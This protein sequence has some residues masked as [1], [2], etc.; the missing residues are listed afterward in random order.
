M[1]HNIQRRFVLAIGASL[2][3]ASASRFA[4]A[5]AAKSIKLIVPFPA[6]GTADVLPRILVEKVRGAYPAGIVVENKSGAGGNIGAEFVAR[7]DA[8]GTT[9]LVS[10]PGPIAINHH[11][12]KSLSFDP[13]K[14]VPVTV[15]ATV[16]N[17]LDVSN[18]L[19]VKSVAEFIAYLKA[20]PGKVSYASQGNGS[21][22]HLT[23][24]LFMELTG[25]KMVHV[26]Y[27]GTAPALV[28]IVA[29]NV[30]VFF[31]NISSS[32][33]FHI[34]N[35]LRVLAVADDERSPAL[36]SVPTFAQAGL[37]NMEAVTFF[38]MV[39]PPGTPKEVVAYAHKQ[40]AA[41]LAA[42]DVKQKFLEQGAVPGGWTPEKT[43]QFIRKESDRW[44]KVIK[45]ANV[46]VE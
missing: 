24:S 26:P 5:Q 15:I 33:Q 28:D 40:F 36:P 9:F 32:A 18:K 8:D 35:K 34:G 43:A 25:T 13:N 4:I 1:T 23:A 20:N 22:S 44:A 21:T 37:P 12:Y 42:P 6:G 39:A 30:D 19:P 2:A 45:S 27:K 11:L 7:A 17:V 31:D 14:W 29:G 16:P 10:P 41:A 38:T 3:T 46:T